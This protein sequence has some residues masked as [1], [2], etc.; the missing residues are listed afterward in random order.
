MVA[1]ARIYSLD[2]FRSADAIGALTNGAS[3]GLVGE[4]DRVR[5]TG[6]RR[7]ARLEL[8]RRGRA[9][10]ARLVRV[11]VEVLNRML[12]G[13]TRSEARELE[14][15]LERVLANGTPEPA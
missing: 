15:L 5:G 4:F 1:Q 11:Q 8:T 14:G 12:R 3:K 13:F 10:H 6:D 2:T 9:L 7:P